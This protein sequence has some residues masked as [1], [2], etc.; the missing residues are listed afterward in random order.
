MCLFLVA[1][2]PREINCLYRDLHTFYIMRGEFD[3]LLQ[4]G[5]A[6]RTR[7]ESTLVRYGSSLEPNRIDICGSFKKPNTNRTRGM[8]GSVRLLDEHEPRRTSP[9]MFGSVRFGTASPLCSSK[10]RPRSTARW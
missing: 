9:Q 7:T 10:S 3:C 4:M 1:G 6:K 5:R 8:F 2:L